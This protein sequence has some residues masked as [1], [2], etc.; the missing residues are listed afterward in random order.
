M[1]E[2]LRQSVS[3]SATATKEEM[4]IELKLMTAKSSEKETE[5]GCL[6]YRIIVAL[7]GPQYRE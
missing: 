4:E 5:W 1:E 3:V 2:S 6:L 7:D